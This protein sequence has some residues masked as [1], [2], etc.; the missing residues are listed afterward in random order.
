M[1]EQLVKGNS[2]ESI[3][4]AIRYLKPAIRTRL[5][6]KYNTTSIEELAKKLQ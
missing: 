4:Q 3:K 5:L 1:F 2:L 6:E